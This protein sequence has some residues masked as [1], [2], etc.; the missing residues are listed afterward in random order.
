MN[1]TLAAALA[2]GAGLLAGCTVN[3]PGTLRL[4][5]ALLY[6]A[7]QERIVWVYGSLGSGAQGSLK[8]GGAAVE[9]RPQVR[10]PLALAGTLSVNG[11]ATYRQPTTALTPKLAVTRDTLGRFNVTFNEARGAVYYTDGRGWTRVNGVQG[12]GLTG[13]PVSG[14]RGAGNLTDAEADALGGAL[15]NQGTLAV[16][17]LNEATV[18]DARLTAEPA[19]AEYRR[20][21]LYLLPGV[22]TVAA[23]PA[24]A[25]VTPAPP[26]AGGR[27]PVTELASGTNAAQTAPAVQL[28]ATPGALGT[29]Y[30]VAYGNQTGAP[31][32]PTLRAGE[33]VVGVFLGQ[34]PTG[35]Y[36]VRVTGASGQGETLTLTVEVRA[37]GAGAIT[38]QAL[39]SPW[40]LVR[41]PG[42]F[43]DVRLVDPSGRPLQL[44]TG[45]GLTR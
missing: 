16:A 28:A 19:P 36:S 17:V 4:H 24:P 41:V 12:A 7:A 30:R 13:T 43:R 18:P 27:V 22:P 26:T 37:P 9:L 1:K 23:G 44:G 5:E 3:G 21:A 29:L 6:G 11:Q 20:T 2:L 31:P 10:D 35:G 8:L 34:R 15:L 33:T 45:G 38:T 42:N 25:P 40:T 32:V 39:T 14:L